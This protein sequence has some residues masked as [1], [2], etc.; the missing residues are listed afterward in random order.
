MFSIAPRADRQSVRRAASV[1]RAE[2]R[3][4]VPSLG[5]QRGFTLIELMITVVVI[6]ILAAVVYPSYADHVRRG[7]IATALGELSA[8][9][10]RLEQYYQDNRNYG[11]S[12]SA[13]GVPMP[14][15]PAFVVSCGWGPGG[16]S[17]SFVVTA[18]GQAGSGM[19][20]Y[21][22]SINERDEQRTVQFA[23]A[24][25]DTACWVKRKGESC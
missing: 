7:K 11:S 15:V 14:A 5:G 3:E 18:T 13:C 6:A 23:G 12:A 4:K 21:A 2:M 16:T 17:Q 1:G 9:R 25:V 22:Y 8:V 19:E 24:T 10:V 20:G